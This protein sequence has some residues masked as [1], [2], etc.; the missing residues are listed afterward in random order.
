MTLTGGGIGVPIIPGEVGNITGLCTIAEVK[1]AAGIPEDLSDQDSLIERLIGNV[2]RFFERRTRRAFTTGVQTKYFDGN[3]KGYLLVDDCL[4]VSAV[5][6]IETDGS[7][8]KTFNI[9][10][11]LRLYPLNRSPTTRLQIINSVSEN[12]HR[13]IGRSPYIFTRGYAN[14]EVTANW[15]SY[16]QVPEDVNGMAIDLVVSKIRKSSNRGLRSVS[17]GG[18]SITF[19]DNDLTEDMKETLQGYKKDF[20]EIW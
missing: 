5:R 12:P 15:G 19:T 14:V 10:N 4:S 7:A 17:I 18:E 1:E 9:A 11:E 8:W 2:T 20:T 16:E 13:T 6:I 3:D